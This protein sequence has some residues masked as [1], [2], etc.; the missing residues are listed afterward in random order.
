MEDI[1]DRSTSQ[2][3]NLGF[4]AHQLNQFSDSIPV[5]KET[6]FVEMQQQLESSDD[7]KDLIAFFMKSLRQMLHKGT[8]TGSFNYKS[9]F[10]VFVV[11]TLR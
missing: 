5:L 6:V 1:K 7:K 3:V 2:N 4:T 10:K 9:I 11:I 8:N